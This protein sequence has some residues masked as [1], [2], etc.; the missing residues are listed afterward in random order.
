MSGICFGNRE[1]IWIYIGGRIDTAEIYNFMH[2]A[3]NL[4][5]IYS[6][7]PLT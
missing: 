2:I 1:C 3:I 6:N 7:I 4:M 5:N